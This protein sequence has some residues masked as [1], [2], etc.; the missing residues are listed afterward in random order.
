MDVS[1]F[2]MMM[3]MNLFQKMMGV[4]LVQMTMMNVSVFM[5]VS[6]FQMRDVS[7][8]QTMMDASVSEDDGCVCF[9]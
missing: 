2:Q 8:F 9:R 5:D 6:V 4:S 7:Q 1:L 3:N